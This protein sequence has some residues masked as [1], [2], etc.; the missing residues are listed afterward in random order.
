MSFF[1]KIKSPR[2]FKNRNSSG[3]NSPRKNRTSPRKKSIL[4]TSSDIK[5]TKKN[6]DHSKELTNLARFDT[7]ELT[8][9][10]SSSSERSQSYYNLDKLK[11]DRSKTIKSTSLN[12]LVRKK[13]KRYTIDLSNSSSVTMKSAL[14]EAE[15]DISSIEEISE[16]LLI[17]DN[18]VPRPP[19]IVLNSTINDL[20][21]NKS[22]KLVVYG[23]PNC[24]IY[25][26]DSNTTIFKIISNI[27][28]ELE[29][30]D[31]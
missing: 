30:I 15:P 7:A 28:I 16:D 17:R 10:I 20:M 11:K 2:H 29:F 3:S 19:S 25:H 18:D 6:I 24:T 26:I 8:S 14:T 31:E 23:K 1:D 4:N 13:N 27:P 9:Y 22:I 5:K 12:D 21:I